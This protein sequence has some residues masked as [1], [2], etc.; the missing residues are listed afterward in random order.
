M[1]QQKNDELK[2]RTLK[3]AGCEEHTKILSNT[4]RNVKES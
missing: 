4:L 1:N 3:E 2:G